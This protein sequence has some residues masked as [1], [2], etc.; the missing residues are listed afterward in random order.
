MVGALLR[1]RPSERPSSR[2]SHIREL[3]CS[4]PGC[5]GR[6]CPLGT[7]FSSALLRDCFS[8][9]LLVPAVLVPA[10]RLRF[11]AF[12]GKKAEGTGLYCR[13]HRS[14]PNNE[15]H[16]Y[17][18]DQLSQRIEDQREASQLLQSLRHERASLSSQLHGANMPRLATT[19]C[20]HTSMICQYLT[21]Y[22]ATR[23]R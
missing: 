14:L 9:V 6:R 1:V 5:G 3:F 18:H 11:L 16:L 15:R 19:G 2:S 7:L 20:T 13:T 10:Q 8:S 12:P 17:S 23:C 4:A 21:A 22:R